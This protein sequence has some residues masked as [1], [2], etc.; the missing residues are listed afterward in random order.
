MNH[1]DITRFAAGLRGTVIRTGEAGYDEART[2]YNAMI[3]RRPRLIVRCAD[4]ADVIAAVNFGRDGKLPIAIRGGGHSAPGFD[5]VDDGL[6]IDMSMIK[7]VRVDPKNRTARVGPGCTT[8]DVDHA[9]YAF[10]QA[11]PFGVVSTTGVAGLT[12]SGGH[13]YLGR[14][15]GLASDNLI[16]ADVVLADG[17]FVTANET[18][19]VDLL[20]AL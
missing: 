5:S 8:G 14:Q 15:Y 11:V 16:E 18:E 7:G 2:L 13:G 4:A 20:W 9:A 1:E 3:D 17:S 12:L 6:V 19:N 10:G